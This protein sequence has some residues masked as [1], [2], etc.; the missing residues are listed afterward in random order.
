MGSSTT[1]V[2]YDT[3]SFGDDTTSN[4]NGT[5]SLRS[6][7]TSVG[8]GITSSFVSDT[9]GGTTLQG[10]TTSLDPDAT[11]LG[12]DTT[13]LQYEATTL[14]YDATTSVN[15]T[16]I[17][18]G[19][20]SASAQHGCVPA[21]HRFYLMVMGY[22]GLLCFWWW[23]LVSVILVDILHHYSWCL[24]LCFCICVT[25]EAN[26]LYDNKW[27]NWLHNDPNILYCPNNVIQHL[28]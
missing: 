26:G 9:T 7:T 28:S 14:D 23:I 3:T 1:P 5:T 12:N 16:I 10:D 21:S 13:T 24:V 15:D 17:A 22:K 18:P 25:H 4:E 2:S 8:Y 20:A 27:L 6:G 11:S 19:N